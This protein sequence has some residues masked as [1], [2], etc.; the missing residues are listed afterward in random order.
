M[1]RVPGSPMHRL[2]ALSRHLRLAALLVAV[3]TL[4]AS[5]QAPQPSEAM[6]NM[7]G[8][9]ELSNVARDMRCVVTFRLDAA[10]PG[11]A[12]GF[13]GNCAGIIPAL[14]DATAWTMGRND[15]LHF[16]DSK[17]TMLIEFTEVEVGMYDTSR[18]GGPLFFLQNLA[19]AQQERTADQIFGEWAMTRGGAGK[20]LCEFTFGNT[21][22]DVDSFTLLVKQGC[23]QTVTRFAPV[24]WKLDRGQ[25]VLLNGKA[26]AWRFEETEP[27]HWRRIPQA[28]QP[29]VLVRQQ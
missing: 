2:I 20:P 28:R 21:A 3:A 27:N 18:A 23:D 17:G 6:K 19:A 25:L 22:H 16:I 7:V 29:I 13:E 9:W 1:F 26:E 24:S 15:A 10:G 14:K 4:P 8:G 12:L 5:A 11:R